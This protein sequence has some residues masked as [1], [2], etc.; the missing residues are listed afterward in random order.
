MMVGLLA[1]P[2]HAIPLAR[3]GSAEVYPKR[4][5]ATPI[6][7]DMYPNQR[8]ATPFEVPDRRSYMPAGASSA[9]G[10]GRPRMIHTCPVRRAKSRAS[11]SS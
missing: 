8:F 9:F 7:A 2:L 1:S 3:S 10:T 6:E 11:S 5:F 4:R